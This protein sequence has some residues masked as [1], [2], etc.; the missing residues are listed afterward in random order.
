MNSSRRAFLAGASAL[1]LSAC[2]PPG[3]PPFPRNVAFDFYPENL[4]CNFHSWIT[5]Y[6]FMI[7]AEDVKKLMVGSFN[8]ETGELTYYE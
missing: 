7:S 1:A 2:V 6:D 4:P 3:T 8:N 5:D